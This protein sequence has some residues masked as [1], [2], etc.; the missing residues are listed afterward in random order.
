MHKAHSILITHVILHT[1]NNLKKLLSIKQKLDLDSE[2]L[3]MVIL[4]SASFYVMA[5][6][7][8]QI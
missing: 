3:G 2:S 6:S 1:E 4:F 7:I 8:S 5:F